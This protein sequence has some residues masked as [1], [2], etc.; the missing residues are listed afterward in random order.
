MRAY[1]DYV[2][3]RTKDYRIRNM[4]YNIEGDRS[5][6]SVL[7]FRKEMENHFEWYD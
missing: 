4:W 2:N 3:Y 5:D 7:V 1:R 6:D